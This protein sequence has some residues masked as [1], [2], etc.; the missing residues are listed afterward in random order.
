MAGVTIRK[1]SRSDYTA[2]ARINDSLFPEHPFHLKRLE[3][4]D[5]CYGRTRYKMMRLVAETESGQ[6]V[7][8]G[9]YKHIFF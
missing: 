7:G 3:Y 6:V 1:F 5:S 2:L 4:E 8:F 9:E